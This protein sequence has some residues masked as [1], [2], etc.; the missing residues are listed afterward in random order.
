MS[1]TQQWKFQGKICFLQN[2]LNIFPTPGKWHKY[3]PKIQTQLESLFVSG[4][5]KCDIDINGMT[6][7]IDLQTHMQVLKKIVQGQG[8]ETLGEDQLNQ[9]RMFMPICFRVHPLLQPLVS[10]T[11]TVS[12]EF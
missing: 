5:S 2:M 10:G 7:E 3:D 9:D 8:A 11:W 1:R 12:S 4:A 6:H